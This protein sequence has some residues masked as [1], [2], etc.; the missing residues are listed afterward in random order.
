MTPGLLPALLKN[1]AEMALTRGQPRVPPVSPFCALG[2][3]GTHAFGGGPRSPLSVFR[4][5][6][7]GG[8]A[9]LPGLW[10]P[11]PWEGEFRASPGLVAA[12][13]GPPA[14]GPRWRFLVDLTTTGLRKVPRA[15]SRA[16]AP[17]PSG[18]AFP[19]RSRSRV[20]EV[21]DR[22]LVRPRGLTGRR[23]RAGAH[24]HTQVGTRSDAHVEAPAGGHTHVA[25][26][27]RR[28]HVSAHT[29]SPGASG[30][31]G[32][33]PPRGRVP[34]AHLIQKLSARKPGGEQNVK[35]VLRGAACPLSWRAMIWSVSEHDELRIICAF[36]AGFGGEAW[37]K[38]GR[39]CFVF[40]FSS[41]PGASSRGPLSTPGRGGSGTRAAALGG[42]ARAGVRVLLV[43]RCRLPREVPGPGVCWKA[44]AASPPL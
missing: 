27:L 37:G 1:G 29:L 38:G 3:E 25:C 32:A 8:D 24:G 14:R 30:R 22:A 13:H 35:C 44:W 20:V 18:S 33:R 43:S 15:E 7:I 40:N 23:A 12:R 5:T 19:A 36:R 4:L 42:G 41:C 26:L 9:A 10:L 17:V 6:G 28:I 21:A 2:L 11:A 34:F 39:L 16:G 31:R